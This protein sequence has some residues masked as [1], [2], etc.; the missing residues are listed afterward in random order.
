MDKILPVFNPLPPHVDRHEHFTDP[1]PM[2]TWTFVTP[3]PFFCHYYGFLMETTIIMCFLI[4]TFPPQ[5][6]FSIT[7]K[8]APKGNLKC[9][10]QL[11]PM[12]ILPNVNLCLHLGAKMVHFTNI[13]STWTFIIPPPSLTWTI[14]D[15]WLPPSPP[16]LV[17]VVIE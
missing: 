9:K 13:L 14:V 12:F 15:I 10:N 1:L 16:L 4:C 3:P 17:H 7:F 8:K 6:W 5:I 2:S 11:H